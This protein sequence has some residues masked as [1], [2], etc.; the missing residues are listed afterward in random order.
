M[1]ER[2]G[3][4]PKE[5]ARK[6]ASKGGAKRFEGMS[7]E[8][9]KAFASQG[10]KARW[11]KAKSARVAENA[12]PP[13]LPEAKHYGF[14]NITGME[15]PCYVLS[16]GRRVI[17]RTATTHMLTGI[18]G[19]GALE[20]YLGVSSLKPFIDYDLVLEGMVSFRLPEVEGLD[21]D[22]KGLPTDLLIEICRGFVAALEASQRPDSTTT[23]TERQAQM[24]IKAGMF[25]ASCA[26][27][28]LD[29]LV[30]EATGYQYE[31]AEDALQVKLA[32]Y[33]E[34]EMR[35]WEKTFPDELWQEFGRLTS[36]KGPLTKRPK[37]WGHLVNELVYG[38]LDKDVA[39]WL[40]ENAPPPRH[41]QNYHQWL[42]GN[43][44]LKR[45]IEHIWMLIGIAKSC[46][47]IT[48]LR[49]KM[50]EIH[51]RVPVQYTMFLMPPKAN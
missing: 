2:E 25:L 5:S 50:A 23:L 26:K 17:G 38:Y 11:A 37:Y 22:V 34:E 36:W 4:D 13:V 6:G 41:G 33:L 40:R 51:G 48:D 9:R 14:L 21:K 32:A 42:S 1:A 35:P 19:G 7:L 16:D 43:F 27:V 47:N 29:A 12:G 39:A 15:L 10:A 24:A 45:L 31:R 44:G 20:K 3:S 30:D 49:R 46:E 18:K 8:E 28:G